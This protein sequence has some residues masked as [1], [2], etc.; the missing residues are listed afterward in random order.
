MFDDS[1]PAASTWTFLTHHARVLIEIARDPDVRLRDI[2]ASIGITERT[3]QN[4]V[5]DLYEA[6]YL[7]RNR[8]GRRNRYSLNLDQQFRYRTEAGVPI[9]LLTDIFT[10]REEPPQADQAGEVP[11]GYAGRPELRDPE[12]VPGLG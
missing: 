12:P 8:I 7:A 3:A 5:R 6:G 4:I 1:S 9:S 11:V 10:R 2:A